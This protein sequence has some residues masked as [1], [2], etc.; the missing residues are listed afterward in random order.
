MRE[1]SP[2]STFFD[3]GGILKPGCPNLYQV[4]D[5]SRWETS[6]GVRPSIQQYDHLISVYERSRTS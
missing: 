6:L 1:G 5:L 2:E 4:E 3:R